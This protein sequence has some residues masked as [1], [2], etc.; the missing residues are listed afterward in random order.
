MAA[1]KKKKAGKKIAPK[2]AAPKQPAK[3]ATPV[4]KL[5]Q[6]VVAKAK[7]LV[8]PKKPSA[9]LTP[10]PKK[11]VTALLKPTENRLLVQVEGVSEKTAGGL[12][13]PSTAMVDRPTRGQVVAK[14]PG[15]RNKKGELRPL[16]VGVGD[17]VL[18]PEFAGTKITL[19]GRELLILS[20][21]EVLAIAED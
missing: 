17:A 19:A 18:F 2:K 12:Y 3:K 4:K 13:I 5:A 1:S 15:K 14:G 8:A 6:K 21:D 20:E 9:K 7:K 11:L 16:D 10:V